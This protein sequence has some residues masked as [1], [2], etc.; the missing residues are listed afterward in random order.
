MREMCPKVSTSFDEQETVIN[1]SPAEHGRAFVFTNVP[2]DLRNLWKLY[3]K[4]PDE[5][6]LIKDDKYGTEFYIPERWVTIRHPRQIPE[7]QRAALAER[8]RNRNRQANEK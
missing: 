2:K 3:N 5:V 6:E 1:S 8:M 7:A 4:Y